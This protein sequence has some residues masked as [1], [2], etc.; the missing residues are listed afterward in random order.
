MWIDWIDLPA[1][2]L[3]VNTL[4]CGAMLLVVPRNRQPTAAMAWLL[5]IFL[6]PIGGAILYLLIGR[7][8]VPRK[9]VQKHRKLLDRVE[10]IR[11]SLSES[12]NIVSPDLP[13]EIQ[14]FVR[15][16]EKL[17]NMPI[18]GSNA[19]EFLAAPQEVI[20]RLIED[21]GQAEQHVHLLFYIFHDDQTGR[22]VLDALSEAAGRGVDCRLLIDAVG[23]H[24]TLRRRQELE[25][26]GIQVVAA[27]PVGKFRRSIARL[28]VRNHRKIVVIDGRVAWTGSQNIIDPDYG[29][30][31]REFEDDM[32]RLRGPIVLEL[33]HLFCSDW[34]FETDQ[35]LDS[36]EFYPEPEHPGQVP[37]QV[38]PSGPNFPTEN[39]SRILVAALYA[40]RERVHMTT[41]YFVPD[42][43][44]IQAMSVA[45]M[46][47]VSVDLI[48]PSSTDHWLV[49][50]AGHAYF[51]QLLEE[52]VRI[53]IFDQKN[54]HAK[55]YSI[56]DQGAFLGSS[57]F[58]I[59]S[60]SL[61]FEVNL[62]FYDHGLAERI[63][64]QQ[65]QYISQS[66]RLQLDAWRQRPALRRFGQN[67]AKL[68]S[69]LL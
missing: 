8:P 15:L 40:A 44:L 10:R 11:Q 30:P 55:M 19:A 49:D 16:A 63:R 69:P 50:A 14:P 32:V 23:S 39:F 42:Q 56:D 60:F 41:P 7:N 3:T 27:L 51:Q 9:R 61:N 20:D 37:I 36:E 22:R 33:Q 67:I 64:R 66:R 26:R 54:L 65:E 28:D 52:G 24:A 4:I 59:R 53:H 43:A 34:Y 17:G 25:Q 29:E 18:L 38:L 62:L 5:L 45:A 47:G 13:G 6:I 46:R 31:G 21:I 68:T 1:V 12:P 57:N 48:V 2:L 35:L 58:D